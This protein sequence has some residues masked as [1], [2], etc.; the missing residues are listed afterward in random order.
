MFIF[1]SEPGTSSAEHAKCL[2]FSQSLVRA[3]LSMQNVHFLWEP[4]T[5]G[6]ES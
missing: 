1:L 4:G 6:D 3:L 2:F 5:C